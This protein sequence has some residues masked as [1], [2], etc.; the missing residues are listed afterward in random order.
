VNK[1][2]SELDKKDPEYKKK[3]GRLH[4][5]KNYLKHRD[6]WLVRYAIKVNRT[7]KL[8]SAIKILEARKKACEK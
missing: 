4:S 2:I 6:K 3:L 7:E 1:E 8:L 5:K